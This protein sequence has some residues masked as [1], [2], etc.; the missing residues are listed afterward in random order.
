[1]N[2]G[3]APFVAT[4]LLGLLQSNYKLLYAN[5]GTSGIATWPSAIM[6]P[7]VN[8]HWHSGIS[9]GERKLGVAILSLILANKSHLKI[10]SS[11]SAD[12]ELHI[13][14]CVSVDVRQIL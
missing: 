13:D 4:S 6:G 12:E 10:C 5:S 11:R 9:S 8:R 3:L 1:L 14:Y 2:Q 7:L